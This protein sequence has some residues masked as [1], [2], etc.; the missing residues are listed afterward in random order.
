ML[1]IVHEILKGTLD[2]RAACQMAGPHHDRACE[3]QRPKASWRCAGCRE[4]KENE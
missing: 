3:L 4:K 1:D 2:A